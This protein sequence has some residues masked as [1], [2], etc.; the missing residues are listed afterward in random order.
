MS[1]GLELRNSNGDVFFSTE[2]TTWNFLGSFIA[3]ANSQA[4]TTISAINLV[5]DTLVQRLFVDQVPG[6]QEAYLHAVSIS[7]TTVTAST[8]TSSG[9]VKTLVVV[10]GR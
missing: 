3:N 2:S 9:K 10:L 7:G 5:T 4:S 8:G 1:Y 6:N